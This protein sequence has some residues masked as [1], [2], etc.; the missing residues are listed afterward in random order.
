M[1][2]ARPY[3]PLQGR[4]PSLAKILG[5]VSHTCRIFVLFFMVGACAADWLSDIS[6]AARQHGDLPADASI[7]VKL[8]GDAPDPAGCP[9]AWQLQLQGGEHWQGRVNLQLTCPGSPHLRWL[10]VLIAVHAP[11]VVIRQTVRRGDSISAANLTRENRDITWTHAYFSDPSRVIDAVAR[12]DLLI[13]TLVTP[14]DL[15]PPLLVRRGEQVL[16]R[17]GNEGITVTDVGTALNDAARGEAVRVRHSRSGRVVEGIAVDQDI[18]A[19][20]L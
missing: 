9:Q 14:A 4:H 1:T 8:M 10:S 6:Q 3:R 11:V 16:L 18:V 19:L 20:P 15:S 13:G 7:A 2:L 17:A 12:H 5:H